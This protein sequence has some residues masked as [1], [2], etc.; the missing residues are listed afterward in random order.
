MLAV[1]YDAKKLRPDAVKGAAW[2][3]VQDVSATVESC[4]ENDIRRNEKTKSNN[5]DAR[6]SVRR[7]EIAA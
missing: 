1:P 6:G 3:K 4:G 7:Q 2:K 5:K